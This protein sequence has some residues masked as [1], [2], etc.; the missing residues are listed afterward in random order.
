MSTKYEIHPAI[1]IARVGNSKHDFYLAP[2]TPG[3]LPTQCDEWGNETLDSDGNAV[4][5]ESFKNGNSEV[6]R[7]AA[8]FKIFVYDDDNPG[9]R[10]IKIGDNVQ[11]IG[12]SGP[13][14]DIQWT[15]YIA[16]KKSVWYQFK[17]TQGEHGYA[18]DHPLR[19]ADITDPMERQKLIIDP[20]PQT[21]VGKNV[22]AEFAKG[23]N[24]AYAQIFPPKLKPHS[25]DTLGEIRTNDN[26]EL[27]VLGGHGKSGSHKTHFSEPRIT[28]YCNNPGW[29][30]DIS[31]GPVTAMLAYYDELDEMVRYQK[32]EDPAWVVV[33]YPGYAPE[34]EDM[35]SMD[36]VI[37]NVAIRHFA[38]DTYM[39]GTGDF[40]N[41]APVTE[42]NL[43]EWRNARKHYNP[44]Y[45]PYFK[46]D[47][48]PIISRP[49][50]MSWV[51]TVADGSNQPHNTGY[52]GNFQQDLMGIPPQ[53]GEDPYG[54]MRQKIYDTLRQSGQEN[55]F[56]PKNDYGDF[57]Y[58][59]PLMP[60]LCGDNPLTN[61]VPAKFLRLTDTMLFILKQWKEGKFIN[62]DQADIDS[63]ALKKKHNEGQFLTSGVLSNGLGGAFNPGAE[64]A[65]IIRDPN[66][67][68][69]SFRINAKAS[70][71]PN[72]ET[73]F[74]G[75]TPGVNFYE[76]PGLTQNSPISEG[77]EPGDLTKYSALPWQADFNECSSQ[78]VDITYE[79]WNNIYPD[80]TTDGA[81]PASNQKVNLT[82]WWPSHR[83][84]QVIPY[85]N[86]EGGSAVDWASGIPQNNNNYMEGDYKMVE[87]WN[88]L[89][90]I[91]SGVA[92]NTPGY[93]QQERN[94]DALGPVAPAELK[95]PG[96]Y[97]KKKPK[98]Y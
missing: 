23:K 94:E 85:N 68:S 64:V 84:M 63:T 44:E 71:L 60:L 70:L 86:G 69:K 47:I 56:A 1:G 87:N 10:P 24:P 73:S 78:P 46:R 40:D 49:F 95:V 8:R 42:D 89:G 75:T 61:T 28:S 4:P 97:K 36:E 39:Y 12:S 18:S 55:V 74:T 50:K 30:D 82:L 14:I 93:Y 90:F 34:I 35:I 5:V 2:E 48:W 98:G 26:Q 65:W 32:V 17:Q 19:N 21:I 38:H 57:Q 7:Q 3:A 59:K 33:G 25:I 58:Y 88:D 31:D 43:T 91:K 11:G 15:A 80:K 6:I 20:G 92:G 81:D 29:Y 37:N 54:F 41:P 77:L 62:E 67:Y 51:T 72:L 13:L 27:I 9:G 22:K 79:E 96:K 66:I 76:R 45:Y 16:N 83:P 52:K 53:G